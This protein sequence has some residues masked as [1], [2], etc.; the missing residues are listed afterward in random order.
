[1]STGVLLF[2]LGGPEK[3]EDVRPFLFNLFSDPNIIHIRNDALRNLLAWFIATT[4]QRKSRGLY[5]QIGG[6]SPLRKITEG[7]AVALSARLAERGFSSRVYVG[8]RCWRPTIDEAV[9][10]ILGDG[11]TK[12]IVLPL[13]PQFSVTTTGSCFRYFRSLADQNGLSSKAQI[14]YVDAWYDNPLYLASM[15]ELI[16]QAIDGFPDPKPERVQL[17]Y[18]AHSI[19]ARYV[20]EGDP[21]LEQTQKTVD[22]INRRLGSRAPSTLAFQSKVGPVKWLE[23]S[24]VDVLEQFGRDGVRQV[25]AIPISFVSDHI[26]TLQE[27]DILYKDLAGKTGIAE[28]RRAAA[29]NLH[30]KFIDALADIAVSRIKSLDGEAVRWP[31]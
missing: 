5:R 10:Q 15:A 25:L 17:L 30:P 21:Y 12:L 2:N 31:T 13:F 18:S 4:R 22:L 26:E 16:E 8:M 23:P 27:I 29:L 6:G 9:T 20:V 14:V 7:Q 19:P 3:L 24:T 11:V 28:F 1:M